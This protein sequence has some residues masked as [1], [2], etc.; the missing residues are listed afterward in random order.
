MSELHQESIQV[1]NN[2]LETTLAEHSNE[3]SKTEL[4]DAWSKWIEE[5]H[6]VEAPILEQDLSKSARAETPPDSPE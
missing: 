1:H 2:F 6:V 3:R 5:T 4:Q